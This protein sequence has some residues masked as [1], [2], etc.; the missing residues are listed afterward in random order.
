MSALPQ[1]PETLAQGLVVLFALLIGHAIADY[2]LQGDFLAIHKDRHARKGSNDFPPT[3]W[4]H[5][6]I[7]HSLVHAGAVW[8]VTGHV[9]FAFA[10]LIL[11]FILDAAKCERWTSYHID[12]LLHVMCK[13][14]YVAIL[15]CCG[16]A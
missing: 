11:H 1:P 4:L 2:P 10:E 3:L 15:L 7:A 12:Q 5:C 14:G 8:I 6:L 13:V 9:A 16:I